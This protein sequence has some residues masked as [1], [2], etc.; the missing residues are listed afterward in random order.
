T[1]DHT[2]VN[3]MLEK[4]EISYEESLDHPMKHYLVRA[5]GISENIDFDIHQVKD[6]DYYLLCSDGLCGYVS[7]DEIIAVFNDP[8]YD[9]TQKKCEE[10]MKLA[11]LKGGYDNI[12]VVIVKRS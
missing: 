3:Q 10:L 12:T 2:L 7:D 6:M 8:A 1:H 11:L 5:I 4:G 9:S